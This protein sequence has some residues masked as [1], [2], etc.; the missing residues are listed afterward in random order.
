VV[1][2]GGG[3]VVWLFKMFQT[4]PNLRGDISSIILSHLGFGSKREREERK[5]KE[6]T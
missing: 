1:G 4:D 6:T 2:G 5:K 3:G